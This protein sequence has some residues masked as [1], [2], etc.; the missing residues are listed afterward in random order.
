SE[1][2][3]SHSSPLEI[4]SA[5]GLAA[6]PGVEI[7]AIKAS[8]GDPASP[9][10]SGVAPPEDLTRKP[11]GLLTVARPCRILAGFLRT[12]AHLDHNPRFTRAQA[13]LHG[14][15]GARRAGAPQ[16]EAHSGRPLSQWRQAEGR[17]LPQAGHPNGG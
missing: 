11:R 8:Y 13:V 15:A 1:A 7:T 4:G 10:S 6:V 16:S 12:N 5:T 9:P 17:R 2:P 3:S 14:A